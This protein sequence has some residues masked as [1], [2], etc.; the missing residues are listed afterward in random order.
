MEGIEETKI[1]GLDEINLTYESPSTG[2][3]YWNDIREPIRDYGRFDLF[4]S[5]M[6]TY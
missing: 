3:T 1:E 5:I 4:Y 6:G 2:T